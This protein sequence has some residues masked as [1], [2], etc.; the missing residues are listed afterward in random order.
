MAAFLDLCRFVASAGGTTDWTY[1]STVSPYISPTDAGAVNGRVY[2]VRAES[3]DLTQWEVS[4]GA[5]TSAGAGSFARTTVLY[6]SAGTGTL[7]SGAGSKISFTAAP[8]VWV[9]A[10]KRDLISIEE[11]N[12]FT[13]GQKTQAR[14][15]I[16]AQADLG[17]TPANKAGDTMTGRLDTPAA[18]SGPITRTSGTLDSVQVYGVS[19]DGFAGVTFHVQAVFA[20]HFGMK[21]DG[22][23]YMGGW[24]HGATSYKFWTTKDFASLAAIATSG[25][26]GDLASGTVPA[27]RL[28]SG[29]R[30]LLN[31]LTA[32]NSANLQDTSSFTSAYKRYEI[33]IQNLVPVTNSVFCRLRVQSGGSFQ[34]TSYVSANT[35]SSGSVGGANASTAEIPLT[36]TATGAVNTSSLGVNGI[37]DLLG[38]PTGTNSVKTFFGRM[39]YNSAFG[40]LIAGFWNNTAAITGIQLDFSSGNISSGTVKIYGIVP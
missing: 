2:K 16:G 37:L 17:C 25:S 12:S 31:T 19:S 38:D 30:V 29:S 9:V 28:P 13:A 6:N 40:Q 24:S 1:S 35:H 11:A 39:V 32:S 10:S 8:Q 26:A 3:V 14:S 20:S 36:T 21:S 27:A 33:E 4:E 22:N 18:G 15:N 34:T 23:Y 5:Y 7:Q